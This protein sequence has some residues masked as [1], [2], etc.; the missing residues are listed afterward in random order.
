MIALDCRAIAAILEISARA[1]RD[2]AVREGW[3]YVEQTCR[4][5]RRRLYPLA[6]LPAGAL[7]PLAL[8]VVK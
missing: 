5:G 8:K 3:P 6:S 1:V 2:R 7:P 4:G